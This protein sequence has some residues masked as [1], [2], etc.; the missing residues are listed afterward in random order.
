MQTG[1]GARDGAIC[2]LSTVRK[3]LA[4]YL[5]GVSPACVRAED[6]VLPY[7]TADAAVPLS[8]LGLTA[9]ELKNSL[10]V[11]PAPQEIGSIS[12][13]GS[14]VLFRFSHAFLER[15]AAEQGRRLPEPVLPDEIAIPAGGAAPDEDARAYALSLAVCAHRS[16]RPYREDK[17][18][19]ALLACLLL[20]EN[21]GPVVPAVRA[22]IKAFDEGL[23]GGEAVLFMAKSLCHCGTKKE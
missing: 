1:A 9:E 3:A 14:K 10:A 20:A 8:K 19:P 12:V 22:V 15:A 4:E 17:A 6:I 16:G 13:F 7:R 21:G 11:T 2:S 18:H 5:S 23:F